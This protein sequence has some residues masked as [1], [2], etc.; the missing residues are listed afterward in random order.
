VAAAVIAE[1]EGSGQFGRELGEILG[2]EGEVVG[3][4]AEAEW[5]SVCR[6]VG[7]LLQSMSSAGVDFDLTSIDQTSIHQVSTFLCITCPPLFPPLYRSQLEG[8][9]QR[10]LTLFQNFKSTFQLRSM[11]SNAAVAA[12]EVS[13]RSLGPLLKSV[14]E[15]SQSGLQKRYAPSLFS[16]FSLSLSTSPFSLCV[17]VCKVAVTCDTEVHNKDRD[18]GRGRGRGR[19]SHC[20]YRPIEAL[21]LF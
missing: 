12:A 3:R 1:W 13:R 14:C 18:R 10:A 4:E 21:S 15:E 20:L 11:R 16:P 6:E 5:G 7:L 9:R 17:Q 2:R 8:R 19:G